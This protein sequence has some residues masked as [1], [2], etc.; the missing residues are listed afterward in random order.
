MPAKILVVDDEPH[1]QRVVSLYL[2]GRDYEVRTA[3][4]GLDAIQ[5]VA[6]IAQT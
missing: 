1:L 6:K 2:R 5:I 4:N 3:P